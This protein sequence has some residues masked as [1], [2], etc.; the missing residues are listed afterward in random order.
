MFEC[1]NVLSTGK[2]LKLTT[3]TDLR[4]LIERIYI[5]TS[6]TVNC[7]IRSRYQKKI[8]KTLR[9]LLNLLH[10]LSCALPICFSRNLLNLS[11]CLHRRRLLLLVTDVFAFFLGL[12]SRTTCCA[13]FSL[14]SLASFAFRLLSCGHLAHD[15]GI[16]LEGCRYTRLLSLVAPYLPLKYKT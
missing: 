9:N 13:G 1:N 11:N 3:A 16:T 7:P 14:G 10:I 8:V 6:G 5:C 2:N 4:E 12:S 15:V